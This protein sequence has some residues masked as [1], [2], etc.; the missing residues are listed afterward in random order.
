MKNHQTAVIKTSADNATLRALSES[1]S[2]S[3]TGFTLRAQIREHNS[4]TEALLEE[5]ER[6]HNDD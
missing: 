3:L 2:R 1:R 5:T 6:L 4:Q